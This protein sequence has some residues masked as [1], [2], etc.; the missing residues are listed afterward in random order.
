MPVVGSLISVGTAT[1]VAL[2]SNSDSRG[3]YLVVQNG[4]GGGNIW[5]GNSTVTVGHGV[6]IPSNA[7]PQTFALGAFGGPIYA[8]GDTGTAQVRILEVY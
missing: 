5:L 3:G 1:P 4:G 2:A 6:S 8:I 7:T